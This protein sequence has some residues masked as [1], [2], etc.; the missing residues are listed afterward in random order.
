MLVWFIKKPNFRFILNIVLIFYKKNLKKPGLNNS[1][2]TLILVSSVCYVLAWPPIGISPL[3]LIALSPLIIIAKNHTA[4]PNKRMFIIWITFFVINAAIS[5]WVVKLSIAGA[6]LYWLTLS[7]FQT[8]PFI[9][10]LFKKANPWLVNTG[11]FTSWILLEGIQLHTDFSFPLVILGNSLSGVP[12]VIQWYQISGVLGGSLWILF[13][14]ILVS[15]S[16]LKKNT[17]ALLVPF[18]SIVLIVPIFIGLLSTP[19]TPYKEL[20]VL[21][22]HTNV[23]CYTEKFAKS[24]DELILKY[25]DITK[26]KINNSTDL[27]L[28]PETAV[29]DFGWIDDLPSNNEAQNNLIDGLKEFSS[30]SLITGGTIYKKASLNSSGSVYSDDLGVS[31]YVY[32]SAIG[33]DF[34]NKQVSI[35]HKEKLVPVEEYQP[36][37]WLT[38]HLSFVYRSLSGIKFSKKRVKNNLFTVKES[39]IL[40]LICFE[41]LYGD[42]INKIGKNNNGIVLIMN[43]GWYDNLWASQQFL[44]ITKIRAI[45]QQKNI[46]ISSNRGHS[47]FVHPDGTF[48][49]TGE[50]KAKAVTGILGLNKTRTLYSQFGDFLIDIAAVALTLSIIMII[51][52]EYF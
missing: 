8:L 25:L 34:E 11:F 26:T 4:A 51:K 49:V 37:S 50:Q 6:A 52:K 10:F 13:V 17:R 2:T 44:A 14:N 45:E 35:R 43:E 46:A 9:F 12:Q 24:S 3:I 47:G 29:T 5:F 22:G 48:E 19:T 7:I 28:W 16:I 23:N 33:L 38:K 39:K 40:P 21:I 31:M 30:A 42:F 41:I 20:K 27:I 36:Y 32:N 1:M 18:A 15:E